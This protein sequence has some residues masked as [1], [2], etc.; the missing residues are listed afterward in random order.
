MKKTTL[1]IFIALLI[2]SVSYSQTVNTG[3][4]VISEGATFTTVQDFNNTPSASL[5]NN[6]ELYAYSHW[7]NDG[8]VDHDNS[9]TTHFEGNEVQNISG[10][11]INYLYDV[12]FNNNSSQPA[13]QL[14]GEI[15]VAN[16][17]D[18]NT[19]IVDSDS[20]GGVF[21]FEQFGDHSHTSEDSHV[22]GEITKV[23]DNSFNFPI[24]DAGYYR[25]AEISAPDNP[26]DT[27]TANYF[28]ENPD[29]N[30]PII[31]RA[32]VIQFIDDQE[33]WVVTK[34]ASNSDV[35]LTLSWDEETTPNFI[36][37]E[38]YSAM[39]IVRWDEVGGFWKD[40]GG[41]VDVAN[42]T[43]STPLALD[44][45]GVFT[46][47]RV[48]EEIIL[49]DNL[50]VNNGIS[51]NGD[52]HNDFF[53][54][55]NIENVQNSKVEIFNRWGA[56]VFS[57]HNYDNVTHVFEGKSDNNL[58]IG[59]SYLPSG[60]YFYLLEYDHIDENGDTHRINEADFLYLKTD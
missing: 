20:F 22:N 25:Y 46:L 30:Y 36:A 50:V 18:F 48:N 56:K 6:G 7:N 44:E 27:F 17:S 3:E 52:G 14:S 10:T 53:Y 55:D 24:G 29:D 23:G 15:S 34:D 51:P 58:T 45:Y 5:I 2:N 32:G 40:E 43:V 39:H 4:L 47:A 41:V 19:G 28:F 16:E 54:I 38:P 12:L 35:I 31:Y 13:F 49:P 57:A 8:V 60:T 37:M 26:G 11:G 33:Y 59:N 9:G 42:K 21:V 1:L